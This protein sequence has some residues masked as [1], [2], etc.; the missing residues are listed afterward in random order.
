[1]VRAELSMARKLGERLIDL[2]QSLHDLDLLLAAHTGLGTILSYQGELPAAHA[3]NLV[4]VVHHLCRQERLA[5]ACAESGRRLA[6]EH[7]FAMEWGRGT[8]LRGWALV[9]QGQE[10][11]GLVQMRHGLG[12]YRATGAEACGHFTLPF[13]PRRMAKP[14]R[15]LRGY[16]C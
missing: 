5:E 2:A 10:E 3:S 11:E 1:M 7:G 14:D 15:W 13:W 6:S 16:T 12:A 8:I 9:V 4:A